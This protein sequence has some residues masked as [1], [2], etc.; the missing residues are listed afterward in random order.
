LYDKLKRRA[1]LGQ[2][3]DAAHD[4]VDDTIQASS[5]ANQFV[6]RVGNQDQRIALQSTFRSGHNGEIQKPGSRLNTGVHMRPPPINRG[7]NVDGTWSGYSSEESVLRTWCK[8]GLSAGF[9]DTLQKI[10][11]YIPLQ[12]IDNA[13]VQSLLK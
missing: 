6:D 9:A 7:G 1:L 13:L 4:A 11:Q 8:N 10:S 3:Q 12:L 2:V 5:T